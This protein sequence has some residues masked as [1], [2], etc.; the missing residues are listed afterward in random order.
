MRARCSARCFIA[1]WLKRLLSY[2]SF[3]RDSQKTVPIPTG[4]E[5]NPASLGISRQSCLM[6]RDACS[7]WLCPSVCAHTRDVKAHPLFHKSVQLR[8]LGCDAGLHKV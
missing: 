3:V 4:I 7:A 6:R 2:R 8:V 1:P 5:M